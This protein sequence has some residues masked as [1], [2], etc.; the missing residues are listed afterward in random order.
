MLLLYV[1]RTTVPF[2]KEI[3]TVFVSQYDDRLVPAG[4]FAGAAVDPHGIR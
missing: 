1:V 2:F 4:I 3:Q